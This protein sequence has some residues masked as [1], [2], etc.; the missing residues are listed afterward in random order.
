MA[1]YQIGDIT[2]H[3]SPVSLMQCWVGT[4]WTARGSAKEIEEFQ[5]FIKHFFPFL[6]A[7]DCEMPIRDFC[8]GAV[9]KI[10]QTVREYRLKTAFL[11]RFAQRLKGRLT[12]HNQHYFTNLSKKYSKKVHQ[13]LNSPVG[14]CSADAVAQLRH[15]G[16]RPPYRGLAAVGAFGNA[17]FGKYINDLHAVCVQLDVIAQSEAPEVQ[18]LETLLHE[19]IHAAIHRE[20][21]DDDD[22]R[23]LIWLNEL[24]AVLTSQ[25]AIRVSTKKSL[26]SADQARLSNAL[27]G[28]RNNQKYGELAEAVLQDTKDALIAVKAWKRIFEL[29]AEERQDYARGCVIGPILRDLGWNAVF[30]YRYGKKSVTVFI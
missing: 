1:T 20:M 19:E 9:G 18:F 13:W 30:P 17:I 14:Q 16:L 25:E 6:I 27:N 5:T 26:S 12:P 23:E 7:Q 24:C 11:M 10:D 2:F 8:S 3:I 22:R 15:W 28:I 29:P 4:G 21:G